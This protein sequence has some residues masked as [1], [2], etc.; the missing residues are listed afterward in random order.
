MC[1]HFTE[2]SDRPDPMP[3]PEQYPGHLSTVV[4]ENLRNRPEP[5]QWASPPDQATKV[6]LW[7]FADQTAY[8]YHRRRLALGTADAKF[9]ELHEWVMSG[10]P[11]PALWRERHV[12]RETG[13]DE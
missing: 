10:R 5:G 4:S 8:A 9:D 1:E 3:V 6:E 13:E 2:P 12:P 11:L 7:E